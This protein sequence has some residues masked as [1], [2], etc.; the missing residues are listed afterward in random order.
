MKKRVVS[1]LCGMMIVVSSVLA[2]C[3]SE[4]AEKKEEAENVSQEVEASAEEEE[5][6]RTPI[7]LTYGLFHDIP[8]AT[9]MGG[10]IFTEQNSVL[11]YIKE[12]LGIELE[13]VIY[14]DDKYELLLAGNELP[15]I[16]SQTWNAPMIGE[17][18]RSGQL[19]E[20][21]ELLESH[22]QNILANAG[23][24]L[25]A[26]NNMYDGVYYIPNRINSGDNPISARNNANYGFKVRYDIY[27]AIGSPEPQNIDE[28]LEMLKEMQDYQ[29][30]ATGDDSIYALA[31]YSTNVTAMMIPGGMGYQWLYPGYFNLETGEAYLWLFPYEEG[32][33]NPYYEELRLYN[34]A[35]RMGIF[36]PDSLI[37]S[38]DQYYEK[39]QNGKLLSTF[40][41][42]EPDCTEL[43]GPEAILTMIPN[44]A[45][46]YMGNIDTM[47]ILPV[48][49]TG[50]QRSISTNCKYPERAMELLNWLDSPE[51]VR[52]IYNGIQGEDWDY[53]DG[54]P[55]YIGEMAKIY[56]GSDVTELFETRTL[57]YLGGS[58]LHSARDMD[59]GD[60]CPDDLQLAPKM[61]ECSVSDA[62]R[63]FAKDY[64]EDCE[65]PGQ[66][67]AKW[68]EEGKMKS[69]N[70]DVEYFRMVPTTTID[71]TEFTEKCKQVEQ[72]FMSYYYADVVTASSEE[73]MTKIF[74]K[75]MEEGGW[76][77][78]LFFLDVLQEYYDSAVANA[79]AIAAGK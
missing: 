62:E 54:E 7:T 37:M 68:V 69:C 43:C 12:N 50:G 14:D 73:E 51:G 65:Y 13:F 18:P 11:Q 67:Y 36:D 77:C 52:M 60:G 72:T 21:T 9:Y 79:D 6:D 61:I 2:G 40:Q 76:E 23:H 19:L 35:Y 63:A 74:N 44:G 4:V 41:G 45:F 39:L 28:F 47:A 26:N 55:Q 17:T 57:R 38:W 49:E 58:N 1:L 70:K 5:A 46:P 34:K 78:Q 8:S 29:R 42:I 64:Y 59:F 56:E 22:G 31:S 66:V 24:V 27:K 71:Y 3:G 25:E 75:G 15:D 48:G 53:V 20:L 32:K 16:V 30:E 33:I 10:G